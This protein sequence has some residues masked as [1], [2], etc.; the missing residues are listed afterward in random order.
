MLR[1]FVLLRVRCGCFDT[2]VEDEGGVEDSVWTLE[3]KVEKML[4]WVQVFFPFLNHWRHS[5][6]V[7][8]HLN[9]PKEA[10]TIGNLSHDLPS[11]EEHFVTFS[12]AILRNAWLLL[13]L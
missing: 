13:I 9:M 1:T 10:K 5:S 8:L 12:E 11:I 3:K 7:F 2:D 6:N 4:H